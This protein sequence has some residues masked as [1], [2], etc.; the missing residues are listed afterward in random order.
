MVRRHL[1]IRRGLLYL[2]LAVGVCAM[3]AANQYARLAQLGAHAQFKPIAAPPTRLPGCRAMPDEKS[4][5]E[6]RELSSRNPRQGGMSTPG[7]AVPAM[8]TSFT[9]QRP[10]ELWLLEIANDAARQLPSQSL[11]LLI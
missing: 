10:V 6:A 11:R 4:I 3:P 9:S 7:A 2:L 5:S 1:P 8:P